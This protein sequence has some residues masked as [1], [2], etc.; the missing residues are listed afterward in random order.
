MDADELQY[1]G[2]SLQYTGYRG[3]GSR[4]G[5]RGN[6]QNTMPRQRR[7]REQSPQ[8]P[9]D[10]QIQYV[11]PGPRQ[12]AHH[13]RRQGR[14]PFIGFKIKTPHHDYRAHME[15]I[16]TAIENGSDI[17]KD[18]AD[19]YERDIK[20]AQ[21][22][23]LCN[24]YTFLERLRLN[25]DHADEDKFSSFPVPMSSVLSPH[26]FQSWRFDRFALSPWIRYPGDDG[27]WRYE[28]RCGFV[29]RYIK[30][31]QRHGFEQVEQYP[32]YFNP[33]RFFT[34]DFPFYRGQIKWDGS[35]TAESRA[36]KIRAQLLEDDQ[37]FYAIGDN[38]DQTLPFVE[39]PEVAVGKHIN[40]DVASI[41]TA[42][43]VEG[44]TEE[45]INQ[46]HSPTVRD[47]DKEI[48]DLRQELDQLRQRMNRM[49]DSDRRTH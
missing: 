7:Q 4:R 23:V 32:R 19:P 8:D 47:K 28:H 30:T 17:I 6:Y 42:F 27:T 2:Q 34:T 35:Y 44:Y 31:P 22:Q 14:N 15:N 11:N 39:L 26:Y 25:V 36:A 5:G 24:T 1:T 29:Y 21:N 18:T 49:R 9:P 33:Y 48:Y 3:R 43:G 40:R 13:V 12:E 41:M 38:G 45:E 37:L 20:I 16:N 10:D 46:Y